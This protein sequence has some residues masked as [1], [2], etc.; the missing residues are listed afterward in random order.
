MQYN[1]KYQH[2]K[3]IWSDILYRSQGM[4]FHSKNRTVL[5][6]SCLVLTSFFAIFS[7]HFVSSH[8]I[9]FHFRFKIRFY[10]ENCYHLLHELLTVQDRG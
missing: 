7:S 3:K 2:Y 4:I 10:S 5:S 9:S 6:S 8:F 1:S